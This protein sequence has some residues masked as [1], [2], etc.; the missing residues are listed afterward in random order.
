MSESSGSSSGPG[1][2][3]II[4]CVVLGIALYKGC[5]SPTLYTSQDTMAPDLKSNARLHENIGCPVLAKE[6]PNPEKIRKATPDD[7]KRARCDLCS[8]G[9][10]QKD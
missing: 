9:N 3:T 4:I 2:F 10:A 1:C 6:Q 8:S 7:M 5:E